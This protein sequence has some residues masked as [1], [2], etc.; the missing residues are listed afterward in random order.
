MDRLRLTA[1]DGYTY[2]LSKSDPGSII[3]GYDLYIES[4]DGVKMVQSHLEN[5][6]AV[7]LSYFFERITK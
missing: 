2:F 5:D 1:E 7:M 4:A 6:E 3:A